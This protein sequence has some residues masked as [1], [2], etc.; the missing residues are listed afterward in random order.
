MDKMPPVPT[1]DVAGNELAEA[2]LQRENTLV[3]RLAN[4]LVRERQWRHAVSN[5]LRSRTEDCV[6][7]PPYKNPD[8]AVH[9][10]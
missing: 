9:G 1:V 6:C 3:R 8:C 10:E 2:L 7:V 5:R 4:D